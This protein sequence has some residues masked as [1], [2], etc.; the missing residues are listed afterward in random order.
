MS[1]QTPASSHLLL[2]A[3]VLVLAAGACATMPPP[4]GPPPSAMCNAQGAIG[5]IGRAPTADVVERARI[6]SGSASVRVIRP[7]DAVTK[8]LRSDRLNLNVN[9]RDA[10]EGVT[11]G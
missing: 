3:I 2:P 4:G 7:G 1:D 6:D 10:I 5:A 8:D 11:C 9:A